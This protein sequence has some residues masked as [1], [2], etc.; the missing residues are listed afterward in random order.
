MTKTEGLAFS[1]SDDAGP[2]FQQAAHFALEAGAGNVGF[3][4]NGI[5][6]HRVVRAADMH[7]IVAA[8]DM[9][10]AQQFDFAGD[11][12]NLGQ[13]HVEYPLDH[14]SSSSL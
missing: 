8:A 7:F 5:L 6:N 13:F 11:L 10:A 4:G 1:K 14:F 3:L 2:P 9:Q 12:G